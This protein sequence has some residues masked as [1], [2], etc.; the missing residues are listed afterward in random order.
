MT[1][2]KTAARLREELAHAEAEE[3]KDLEEV[4]WKRV[5]ALAREDMIVL[6][7]LMNVHIR[8]TYDGDDE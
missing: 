7:D 1:I 3:K 6:R 2:K 8:E 5:K 4:L